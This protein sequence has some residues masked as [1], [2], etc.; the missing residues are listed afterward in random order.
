M[1]I[2][3]SIMILVF[4]IFG[5]LSMSAQAKNTSID[6]HF[7]KG[8]VLDI[9]L[10]K[11]GLDFGAL[12]PKYRKEA[13]PVASRFSFTPVPGFAISETTQGG[14]Q[15]ES[16]IFGRWDSKEKREGFLA[17]IV[18][19]VPDFHEQ[20]RAIWTYFSLTYYVMKEDI[21][22]TIDRTKYNVVTSYWGNGAAFAAYLKAIKNATTERGGTEI[23]TLTEGYSPVGY[24]YNP[25][26][27][28]ITQWESKEIFDAFYKNYQAMEES[29]I[30]NVHQFVLN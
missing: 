20:R 12:F 5:T 28:T 17:A 22:L 8:E 27:L 3:K 25:D 13:F 30:S 11:N 19:A 23:I 18:P 1:T 14:I 15:P 26:Y 24:T 6:Y 2:S 9:L 10:L 21:H 29:R 7:N 4:L 16:M